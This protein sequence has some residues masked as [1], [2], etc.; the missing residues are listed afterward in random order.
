MDW[1]DGDK[2]WEGNKELG[3]GLYLNTGMA[4]KTQSWLYEVMSDN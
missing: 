4:D 1:S 2:L 3:S